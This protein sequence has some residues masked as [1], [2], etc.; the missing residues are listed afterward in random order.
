MKIK[1]YSHDYAQLVADMWNKSNSSWG[2]DESVKTKEEVISSENSSGNLKT[3]LA[4]D[5]DEVVGYCSF[6]EYKHDE[7]ASYLP[8]LN[9]TPEYHG[10]KVGKALILKV[11]ED[12]VKSEWQRFDLYTWSGNIKAMPLYKKCGFF[13]EKKNDTVHL[14]NFIPYMFQTEALNEYTSQIDWYKDSIREIDMDQDGFLS[15]GFEY[16]KYHFKNDITELVL[17]FEKT[18][19]GLRLIDTPDYK[20]EMKLDKNEYVINNDYEVTFEIENKSGK[21]LNVRVEGMNNKN[22]SFKIN[23]ELSVTESRIVKG[24]FNV[25][26]IKKEQEKGKTHPVVEANVYINGKL[27]NFKMGI[28]PQFPVQ[29]KLST[30][31]YNHVLGKEYSAYLD[32]VNNLET[33][34]KFVIELPNNFVKF[35]GE[36]EIELEPKQ[37][38]S[39]A[40]KYELEGYGYYNEE[41]IVTYGNNEIRKSVQSTFK[42]SLSSFNGESERMGAVF[43]GN[44]GAYY[45]KPQNVLIFLNGHDDQEKPVIFAAQLGMPYS[46][47]FN[48]A[49]PEIKFVGSNQMDVI[50]T[51]NTF[52]DVLL[53]LHVTNNFGLFKLN[54]EI[55]NNGSDRNLSLAIPIWMSL[56]DCV[57][58][59][60]GELLVIDEP[61]S[62]DFHNLS[63][64]FIDENWIYNHKDNYGLVWDKSYDMKITEWRMTFDVNDKFI[65]KGQSY[66]S[67]DFFISCVHNS[68]KDF[69]DFTGNTKKKNESSYLN[70]ATQDG[71]PFTEDKIEYKVVNNKKNDLEGN[72]VVNSD[73]F[74][75]NDKIIVEPGLNNILVEMND[76][77]VHFKSLTFK[78]FGDVIVEKVD[79]SIVVNNGV[80]SFKASEKY[81]DSIYSLQFDGHEWLDSNY[82]TPKERVWWGDFVGGITQRC[83]GLQD[84]A[85]LK[86]KREIT[87]VE[88]DDN[89]G[90]KWI[91]IKTTLI[92]GNDPILKG[93]QFDSYTLT[94]PG[95]EVVHTFTNV[96][97]NTGKLLDEKRL[98]RFNT[99]KLDDDPLKVKM[100]HNNIEYKCN[101]KGMESVVKNFTLLKSSR[102]YNLAIYNKS[103]KL[104]VSSQEGFLIVFSDNKIT[105]PDSES[106]IY[107]GDYFVFSKENLTKEMLVE[108]KN[109]KFEV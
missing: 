46:L 81:A 47:E 13:W 80:L 2:N 50:F 76:K 83:Q 52:K 19:R 102:D 15:N 99:L 5:N 29:L 105:L 16:Y 44:F 73:S 3:Y 26:S 57:V 8:L 10:K 39:L 9:V 53:V 1:E 104:D 109:I 24:K 97:N 60:K 54:Y 88:L 27:A 108:L 59:Y 34:Q 31:V 38:R 107:E 94:L 100:I 17:E 63:D 4:F 42:G 77:N 90:N 79:D 48:N 65:E 64:K 45:Y 56:E 58:P 96:I 85:A 92:V 43:S 98:S 55:I 86:E 84:I 93:L 67:P 49:K 21:E 91:G 95:V 30:I 37:K 7:G 22:I 11:L 106:V 82:P 36:L 12:A 40:V 74:N 33:T 101:N 87:T 32:V 51:S 35:E 72:I 66:T 70:V 41:C 75:M 14:M 78:K 25:G 71:N 89:L 69:R 20:I 6:S 28:E 103:N 23:S 18:G 68:F 61:N 62:S